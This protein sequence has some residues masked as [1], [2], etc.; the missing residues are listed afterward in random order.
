MSQAEFNVIGHTTRRK[1]GVARVTGQEQYTVDMTLPRMLYGRYVASPY[2]HAV[3]KSIDTSAAE[4]LGAVVIT[5]DDVPHVPFNERIVSVPWVL[6]KDRFV[7]AD[8]VRRMGEPVAA[9]AAETEELAERA[10]RAVRVEYEP[11]PVV[12]DPWAA[13]QPDAPQLYDTVAYGLGETLKVENNVISAREINEGDIE[14]AF[15]EADVFVEGHFKTPKIYHMQMEPKGAV[16]KPEPDGGLTVWCTTQS[17]HNVRIILGQVFNIPL[18]KI[19][20]R[21]MALGGTFG[22]SIQMNT[23]IPV[24]VALAL[25]AK[26]PVKISLTRE[27]DMHDHSKYPSDIQLRIG[28]RRDGTLLGAE[29]SVVADI[30]AHIV[31]G[32]S[33]LGVCAGWLMSLYRFPALRYQGKAVYTNKGPSC[34]MQ[35]FGNPQVTFAVESLMD[36][37]ARKLDMDP[38]ELRLKNYVGLGDTSWGQGPMVKSIVQSDGVP[39]L[40]RDGAAKFGWYEPSPSA[41]PEG[42]GRYRRGRGLARGFHTSSAG[43]PAPGDV[44]DFSGAMVKINQDGS[45]DVVSAVMDHGGGTLEAFAKLTAEALCVPLDKVDVSPVGTR[46]SV[47]DVVT[48]ATRGI[49]AGGGAVLKAT[50]KVREELLQTAGHYM[51]VQPA[52]LKLRLDETLG[53]GVVYAPSLPGKQMT[54]GE[55]ASRCWTDSWKTIAAVES[56]RPVN[57]P[58][59]YVTVFVEV[60]VDIQTGVVRT[61]KAVMGGDSGT[62][63]NPVQVAGQ[64]EGGLSKGAGFAL[65]ENLEWDATGQL[66]SRGFLVDGKV[67]GVNESPH[68]EGVI[69]HFADTFEPSGPFGAKGIGEA[70]TNPVAGAYANAIRDALGIRFY[71]L[72]ITPE[73]ILAALRAEEQRGGGAEEPGREGGCVVHT[74]YAIRNTDHVSRVTPDE[75]VETGVAE[76]LA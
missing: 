59:C 17:I 70:A 74:Q 63:I 60:E 29:M 72:P 3:V 9:V 46:T 22:S 39:Q 34:A 5:W 54:V 56:Y 48:H 62:I 26:R 40:L 47:Y 16:C 23:V 1:D 7:L 30:G 57:C 51:N 36:E 14:H 25:K 52:A 71:E 37:L 6:H 11:L 38:I 73:K 67:A 45:V 31:Q 42:Q 50:Q 55:I 4:A 20:V 21:R 43:A 12:T 41:D 13:M 68:L 69:T 32:Y 75:R 61:V 33:Y 44:I 76:V 28:A 65:Y 58:P 64:L 10:A 18:S 49:Y 24:T 8:K 2:A 19:D 15:A 53:Q 66:R 27:E 35:G